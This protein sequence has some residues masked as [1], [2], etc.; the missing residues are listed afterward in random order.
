MKT[1]LT[2]RKGNLIGRCFYLLSG[3]VDE[4]HVNSYA[5]SIGAYRLTI[6]IRN[7]AGAAFFFQSIREENNKRADIQ[8]KSQGNFT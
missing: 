1:K 7:F 2:P 4:S 8:S 6:D 5:T 3:L